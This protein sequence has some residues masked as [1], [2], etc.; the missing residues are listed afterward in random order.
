M[1]GDWVWSHVLTLNFTNP[2]QV[3]T[4][5]KTQAKSETQ[6]IIYIP[7]GFLDKEHKMQERKI[8]LWDMRQIMP[9]R[10]TH[11]A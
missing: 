11:R 9:L 10:R 5:R 7:L 1:P 6:V 4:D 3:W 2:Y 8:D